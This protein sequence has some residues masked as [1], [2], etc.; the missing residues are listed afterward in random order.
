MEAVLQYHRDYRNLPQSKIENYENLFIPFIKSDFFLWVCTILLLNWKNWKR[1]VIIILI[2]HWFLRSFGNLLNNT[3]L[4]REKEKNMVWPYSMKNWYI[5][6]ALAHIFWLTGEIIGDWYPL[7]RTKVVVKDKKKIRIV[8]CTCIMYNLAKV[9][10]MTTYFT[11]SVDLRAVVNN[12]VNHGLSKFNLYWWIAVGFIQVTSCLYDVSVIYA[13]K[14]G[15]FNKLKEYSNFSKNTFLDK[16]KGISELRIICS[17]IISL[18]FLPFLIY[19]ISHLIQ[20]YQVK[21]TSGQVIIDSQIEQFRQVVLSFNFTMMYID[22]ILL[23]RIVEKKNQTYKRKITN[24]GINNKSFCSINNVSFTKIN[25]FSQCS[26]DVT[27]C[28]MPENSQTILS[29][30]ITISSTYSD[31]NINKKLDNVHNDSNYHVNILDTNDSNNSHLI[32][33]SNEEYS[34]K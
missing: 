34:N 29:P 8:Y 18:S 19:F 1:P 23:R 33:I 26:S 16:F 12:K 25:D 27:K 28:E 9:Y 11:S 17:M 5:S 6:Q 22:Q 13:L 10:G 24:N 30:D 14:T 4:F 31:M 15:L 21:S 3:M 7:L 2:I 32:S 20:R